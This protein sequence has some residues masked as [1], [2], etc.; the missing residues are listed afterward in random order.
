LCDHIVA[1]LTVITKV[2]AHMHNDGNPILYPFL[3]FMNL[4]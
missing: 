4:Y 3:L 2:L 1:T